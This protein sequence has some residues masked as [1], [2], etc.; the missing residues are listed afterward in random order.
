LVCIIGAFLFYLTVLDI[1]KVANEWK[2]KKHREMDFSLF[3]NAQVLVTLQLGLGQ[4]P[5]AFYN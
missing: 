3:R 2:T 5:I 4:Y 1:V